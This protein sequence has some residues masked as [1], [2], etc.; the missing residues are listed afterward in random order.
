MAGGKQGAGAV[1]EQHADIA[2]AAFVDSAE[3]SALAA[4]SFAGRQ[5]EKTRQVPGGAEAVGIS[6]SGYECGGG[7][8]SDSRD[9]SQE[10]D[11]R[12]V[13]GDGLELSLGEGDVVVEGSNL[14]DEADEGWP[15]RD[16]ERRVRVVE[17]GLESGQ[18][19]ARTDRDGE[20]L[21]AQ[22]GASEVEAG[23]AGVH[24]GLAQAV[25]GDDGLLGGCLDGDGLDRGAAVG[26]R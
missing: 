23:G 2:V 13:G 1:G 26:A 3:S 19:V 10:G 8:E 17:V 22:D 6:D 24:P 15:Q 9:G 21:F 4:R 20:P 12:S 11:G 5:S 14:L 18:D 25:E 7:Q 16:G